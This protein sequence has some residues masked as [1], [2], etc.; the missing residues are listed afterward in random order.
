MARSRVLIPICILLL[1]TFFALFPVSTESVHARER[2]LSE[3]AAHNVGQGQQLLMRGAFEQAAKPL[4]QAAQAYGKAKAPQAQGMALTLL[5]QVYQA[6]G[7]YRQALRHLETALE[8]AQQ[9]GERSRVVSILGTLG[10]IYLTTGPTDTASQYLQKGLAMAREIGHGLLTAKLLNNLGNLFTLQQQLDEAQVA[11]RECLE[12]AL[13]AE[14]RLLAAKAL[15]NTA[16]VSIRQAQ[17]GKAKPLLDRAMAQLSAL[18]PTRD[19]AY[20][21]LGLGLAYDD[22]RH[23]LPDLANSL[24]RSA[25]SAFQSA[26]E[27]ATAI[28]DPRSLS[29]AWGY[30]GSLYETQQRYREALQL[31]RRAVF[32]VQRVNAPESRYRWEWPTGRL[33]VALK[34]SD[35]AVAAYQRAVKTVQSLN[36]D[37]SHGPGRTQSFRKAIQPVYLELVDLLLQRAA[38]LSHRDQYQPYLVQARDI[39]ESFKAAE[40]QDYFLDDCVTEAMAKATELDTVSA[41]AVIIY[42][43]LLPDRTE[44]LVSLPNGLE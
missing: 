12:L 33:L 29:Y 37:R 21:L 3:Q 6:L 16:S 20:G 1:S 42:S 17:Y 23:T 4:Q 28:D 41:T 39:V 7:Q 18:A 11:Y 22:L 25:F 27:V 5:A 26:A 10:S 40:L 36:Q 30:L 8:L 35:A 38:T 44:L 19:K 43:I 24:L 2:S 14:N 9:T 31:T 13:A 15:T 32:A 34:Q